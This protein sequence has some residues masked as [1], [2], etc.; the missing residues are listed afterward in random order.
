M[1]N[2]RIL[3]GVGYENVLLAGPFYQM[4]TDH[5]PRP[6]SQ[7][8]QTPAGVDDA[9]IVGRDPTL[10]LTD[11]WIPDGTSDATRSPLSGPTGWQAFFNNAR[12]SNPFRFVPDD[13]NPSFYVDGCYLVDPI[14]K[15]PLGSL[16][17]EI[18]RDIAFQIRNPTIDF[19]QALR[20]IMWEYA[21]QGDTTKLLPLPTVARADAATCATYHDK[22][23]FVR[24]APANVI[25][26]KHY[27]G[28]AR[29]TLLEATSA[30][31]VLQP[32]NF[33]VTWTAVGTPTRVAGALTCGVLSLDLIGDDSAAAV[34]GYV[35]TIGFTGNAVK[36]IALYLS[37]G[38]I[39]AASGM[40][41]QLSDDT[42][43]VNRLLA[44]VT[45]SAAG[46]PS[47]V[48]T[49]GTF[50][51]TVALG[52]AVYRL[53]FTTTAVTA[54][55]LNNLYLLG[56]HV[57]AEQGNVYL[58]GVQAENAVSPS[59]YIQQTVASLTRATDTFGVALPTGAATPMASWW[60]IKF[61]ELGN[62]ASGSV[63]GVMGVGDSANAALFLLP[64][65]E[66][67]VIHRRA[68]DAA[69]G[70]GVAP[71]F[72]DTVELLVVLYADGSVVIRQ[73]INGAAET[74]G[75]TSAANAL[76]TAW[77]LATLRL[78]SRGAGTEGWMG[79]IDVRIGSGTA[80]NT[81]ALARL[82]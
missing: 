42:A 58:G 13:T 36:G 35:Q 31:L 74:V 16:N 22:A 40:R 61:I 49:N 29:T 37:A 81:I 47:A 64:N 67:E 38:T 65:V 59:S 2:S 7:R 69:S 75:V 60:Y 25:R 15:G 56:A 8:G 43:A 44:V 28:T 33:G 78:N 66:Y 48:M 80:V 70:L 21:P 9:F 46:V 72:G 41:I 57:A 54:A 50:L 53:E 73:S 3:W 23:G 4:V 32:E 63:V 5:V 34:E 17:T 18:Q 51:R 82:K 77:S 24:L 62:I 71:V 19:H 6:P 12:D 76:A 55:N 20:G 30:N 52:N 79:L 14:G 68:A 1:A 45:F 27:V 39:Q 10:W 11:R 26:D